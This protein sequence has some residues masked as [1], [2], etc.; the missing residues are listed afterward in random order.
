MLGPSTFHA[1]P[2]LRAWDET[3]AFRGITVGLP[4]ALAGAH[5]RPGQVVK[6]RTP[7]G[8]GFFALASAPA[9]SGEADLLVKR[10]GKIADALAAAAMPGASAEVTAPFGKGFPVEEAA[11]RDVL[12]FAAGS[13]IAPVRA[14]VQHLVARRGEFGRA[15]LFYGQRHGA[16]FAYRD[17]APAWRRGGV[18]VVLCP[19]QAD[20]SW[21]GVRGHVQAVARSL[22]FGGHPPDATVAFVCGMKAMVEDVRAMLSDFGVPPHRVHANF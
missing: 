2:V 5:E 7:A 14:L 17:E 10:G 12:L 19:S 3:H 6:V 8:E 11:G 21:D 20:E 4:A 1:V 18:Q 16:E 22:E 9:A 15:T 13:G